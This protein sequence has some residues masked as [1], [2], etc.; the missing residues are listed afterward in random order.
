MI[1]IFADDRTVAVV[2]GLEAAQR[3]CEEIDVKSGLYA[4]FDANGKSLVPV[5]IKSKWRRL[6]S[7]SHPK[8]TLETGSDSK[9]RI[10]PFLANALSVEQNPWFKTIDD[11]RQY[12]SH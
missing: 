6:L 2:E 9:I 1:F 11:I 3:D 12:F 5:L 10:E 4:F 8:F 7:V